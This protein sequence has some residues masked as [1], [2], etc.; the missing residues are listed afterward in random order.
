MDDF[1]KRILFRNRHSKFEMIEFQ[2]TKLHTF[3]AGPKPSEEQ[4]KEFASHMGAYIS[5]QND[6]GKHNKK[7]YGSETGN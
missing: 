5:F 4:R 2:S 6:L 3:F 1:C 7:L